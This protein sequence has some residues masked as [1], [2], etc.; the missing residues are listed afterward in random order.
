[1]LGIYRAILPKPFLDFLFVTSEKKQSLKVV[2]T[3]AVV[4][5]VVM[6]WLW[7]WYCVVH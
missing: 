3:A 2:V 1:M 6:G 7:L 4:M 5:A